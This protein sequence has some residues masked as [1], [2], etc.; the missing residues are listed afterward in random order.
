ME[1]SP[2]ITLLFHVRILC[3]IYHFV[4]SFETT[5]LYLFDFYIALTSLLMLLD[6]YFVLLAYNHTIL[7]GA[8]VQLVFGFEVYIF[9]YIFCIFCNIFGQK[10]SSL[11]EF[12]KQ[13]Q[14]EIKFVFRFEII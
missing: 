14:K 5:F 4:S 6:T 8:S 13:F 9:S 3:K 12:L 1:R 11:F 7:K 10:I 2:V